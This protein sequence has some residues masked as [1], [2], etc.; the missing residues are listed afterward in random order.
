MEN[1]NISVEFILNDNFNK[2]YKSISGVIFVYSIKDRNSFS[3][4]SKYI[5]IIEKETK[6][7]LLPK[8]ILGIMKDQESYTREFNYEEA[9]N[10]CKS[11]EINFDE[12]SSNESNKFIGIIK[13]LIKIQ[14]IYTKYKTFI[15]Q[16]KKMKSNT[17][18]ILK[19]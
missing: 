14:K 17:S 18:V 9:K 19:K 4:L 15:Y 2:N 11:K 13:N 6:G 5:D 12:I 8:I 1:R 3:S 7:I 16:N 10:F